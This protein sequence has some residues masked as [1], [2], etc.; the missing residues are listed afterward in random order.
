MCLYL[1]K[2]GGGGGWG[3]NHM[4]SE[5]QK[6]VPG[7]EEEKWGRRMHRSRERERGERWGRR[8]FGV[9]V[10]LLETALPRPPPS[11]PL[12]SWQMV[13]SH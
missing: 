6:A 3:V 4:I 10:W 11:P 12:L 1:W 13:A 9:G 5:K 8:F 7:E 2:G